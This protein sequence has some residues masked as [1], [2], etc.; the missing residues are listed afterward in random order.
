MA[1]PEIKIIEKVM[2]FGKVAINKGRLHSANFKVKGLTKPLSVNSNNP[3]FT[4]LDEDKNVLK[5]QKQ[6][7][8]NVQFKPTEAIEEAG[9]IL[10]ESEIG[11]FHIQMRGIGIKPIIDCG[12]DELVLTTDRDVAV[13]TSY[14]LNIQNIM[15][16]VKVNIPKQY[17]NLVR[18]SN[19]E[20]GPW[21][22]EI[23]I[24]KSEKIAQHTIYVKWTGRKSKHFK[25]EHKS[26]NIVS[27]KRI[28][29]KLNKAMPIS[30]KE[31]KIEMSEERVIEVLSE[32]EQI[33]REDW[34]K[35]LN[36]IKKSI[37]YV[38]KADV[39]ARWEKMNNEAKKI[40]LIL[41]HIH[42]EF[43]QEEKEMR[44]LLYKLIK[45]LEKPTANAKWVKEIYEEVKRIIE[46]IEK[47]KSREV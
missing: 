39:K 32:E 6:A 40:L 44:A 42:K 37:S 3:H 36:E 22:E 28:L 27:E 7:Q 43:P 19:N 35:N 20:K 8:F 34:K 1:N 18:L 45:N 21:K 10:I 11:N 29:L 25:I 12:E 13:I 46:D 38:Y 23:T 5:A 14:I 2:N 30:R 16:E 47:I 26:G 31:R 4:I 15:Q 9:S 41:K 24:P 33:L 17:K